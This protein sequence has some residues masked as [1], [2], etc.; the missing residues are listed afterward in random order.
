MKDCE[1]TLTKRKHNDIL[2]AAVEFFQLKGFMK[3]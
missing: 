1:L 3:I 2:K